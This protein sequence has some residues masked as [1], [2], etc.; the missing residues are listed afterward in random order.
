M[1]GILF[2]FS[3]D[4]VFALSLISKKGFLYAVTY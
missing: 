1:F 3:T 4:F 2:I